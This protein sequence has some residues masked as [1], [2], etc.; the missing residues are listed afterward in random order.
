MRQTQRSIKHR[1][2]KGNSLGHSR[3]QEQGAL[4]QTSTGPLDQRYE[5][6]LRGAGMDLTDGIKGS[7][8]ANITQY[9]PDVLI[10]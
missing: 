6:T 2:L 10:R 7:Q 3:S 4:S 5:S 9:I 1:I 8:C